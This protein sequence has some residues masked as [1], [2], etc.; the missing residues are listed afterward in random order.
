MITVKEAI[1]IHGILIE[2]FGGKSGVRDL[3]ALES[4]INRPYAT[5]NRIE[6]YPNPIE[7]AMAI[8]ESVVVN[9]PF[10]DGNKRAGYVL[11]RLLLLSEDYDIQAK[12]EEKYEFVIGIASGKLKTD[13]IRNWLLKHTISHK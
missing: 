5:F 10:I 11:M 12:E 1:Q 9:H 6:L 4:A 3:G 2:Q 8:I 13:E 7:K